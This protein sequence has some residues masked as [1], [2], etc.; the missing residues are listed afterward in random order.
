MA[1]TLLPCSYKRQP[2]ACRDMQEHNRIMDCLKGMQGLSRE[3]F[4]IEQVKLVDEVHAWVTE[5]ILE[6]RD[7]IV[8]SA[9]KA[10]KSLLGYLKQLGVSDG[11]PGYIEHA[12]EDDVMKKDQL[13]FDGEMLF[14]FMAIEEMVKELR[15]R[16]RLLELS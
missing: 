6:E 8:F 11:T 9:S 15:E 4:A 2:R 10:R 13:S 16:I 14:G 7:S 1:I 5:L 12:D 3:L